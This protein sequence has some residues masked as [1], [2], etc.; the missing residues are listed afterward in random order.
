[1][2]AFLQT[3][4]KWLEMI[5][6]HSQHTTAC[7]AVSPPAD[8]P[9]LKAPA[10]ATSARLRTPRDSAH[11]TPTHAERIF[12]FL[13]GMQLD[14]GNGTGFKD[15]DVVNTMSR[16][17]KDYYFK[18]SSERRQELAQ[19]LREIRK[20]AG[21]QPLS[22]RVACSRLPADLKKRIISKL[23]KQ[24]EAMTMGDSVKYNTWVETILSIPIGE[25]IVPQPKLA[26]EQ[27]LSKARAHLDSVVYGHRAAK[28]AV[29]ERFHMWLCT[30]LVPQ[31]PLA[32]CGVPGNG[33]TTLVREGLAALM[34]RPFAFISLGG[35]SDSSTLLGHGYTYEGSAPGR[36]AEHIV[37]GNCLN[38]VFYFD[39]L[40]KCSATP[41]GEEIIN[42]LIHLTD[43]SQSDRFRDRYI[44]TIDIDTSKALCVFTF[45]D[46]SLISPILMDRMQ[47]VQTDAFDADA[48]AAIAMKHIAPAVLRERNL[49]PN[50]ITFDSEA[51]RDLAR[52]CDAG[53]VRILRSCIEQCV[54]KVL[55]WRDCKDDHYLY[56]LRVEDVERLSSGGIRVISGMMRLLDQRT[57][58][59]HLSMY[60]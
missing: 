18:Q 38:P 13:D 29:I 45:N 43:V 7:A 15:E 17:E 58:D 14:D 34:A 24:N 57:N 26:L 28:A 2:S 12:S 52:V 46:S 49:K 32:L 10:A 39:E 3:A 6:R 11:P 31:R 27:T 42:A 50:A 33:K 44:G 30:P 55:L 59:S 20:S 9:E 56:P 54:S 41:K 51:L 37:A 40:D 19:T 60:A 25:V 48:R 36:V 8:P 35:S 21:G 23:D 16:E 1:M 53:G 5:S 47:T 4:E 22:F